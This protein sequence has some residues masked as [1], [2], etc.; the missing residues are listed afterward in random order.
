MSPKQVEMDEV[1]RGIYHALENQ[2]HLGSTLLVL[3]GDHGMNDA[4]NHGGTSEGETSP[5]LVFISPKLR[6]IFDGVECPTAFQNGAFDFYERVDQTDIAPTLA[7][8]LGFPI[9]KNNLGIVIPGLL[10]FWNEGKRIGLMEQNAKQILGVLLETFPSSPFNQSNPLEACVHTSDKG[11]RLACLWSRIRAQAF[12]EALFDVKTRG[13]MLQTFLREAQNA[14]SNTATN[15]SAKKLY[16][17]IAVAASV[18]L[19]AAA[20]SAPIFVEQP[21]VGLWFTF[22]TL[23]YGV[24]MF[25]SSYVEEEHQYW[26]LVASAWL[27][28]LGVKQY[29]QRSDSGNGRIFNDLWLIMWA[30]FPLA[31]MRV[32]RVWNQTGQK[33]AGESDI[34]RDFLQ[35]HTCMLWTIV[36]ILY[37]AVAAKML[38]KYQ[39]LIGRPATLLSAVLLCTLGLAF[40]VAYSIADSPE[41][42][43]G[44]PIAPGILSP[45]ELTTH[46]RAVFTGIVTYSIGFSFSRQETSSHTRA[47]KYILA[48]DKALPKRRHETLT[49]H[50]E[51][52]HGVLTFFLMTQSRVTNIPMFAL[53]ELQM[54]T[55]ASMNL[56]PS[57]ISLTAIILQYA[58]FFAF[59]GSNAI[60]SIDLSNSYNGVSGYNAA[61]VG[62]L[63][64]CSNWAGPI[65]WT[66]ASMI[67]LVRRREKWNGPLSDFRNIVTCFVASKNRLLGECIYDVEYMVLSRLSEMTVPPIG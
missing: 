45:V 67:L 43:K 65:W 30:A 56:S 60:S 23:A 17:G 25:A 7:T 27:S 22:T 54:R 10:R 57:E 12:E 32:V 18:V 50:L 38:P 55:L 26:Y 48:K 9:P 36:C 6:T 37:V 46:A 35:H 3:C 52:L 1:V 33:H 19:S 29:A 8:L 2:R 39:T 16:S 11:E 61:M 51:F 4:G 13:A 28:W 41:L 49:A 24:M 21:I 63:T 42:L 66:F 20:K 14:M 34:A 47:N 40:K 58:S 15:Y 62:F 64:F 53:F 31:T 5:A 59:G 44:L